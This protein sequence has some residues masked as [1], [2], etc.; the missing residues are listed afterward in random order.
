MGVLFSYRNTSAF[1]TLSSKAKSYFIAPYYKY[2]YGINDDIE[3]V[4]VA[5]LVT[6]FKEMTSSLFPEGFEYLEYGVGFSAIPNYYVNEKLL[7]RFPL[8]VQT[9][10]KYI[11]NKVP[12]DIGFI[13]KAINNIGFQTSI[14]YGISSEY[15]INPRWIV[16]AN[17]LR[18]STINDSIDKSKATYYSLSTTYSNEDWS[19]VLGYKTVKDIANYSENAYMVSVQY[20]W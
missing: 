19:Y 1:D 18:T 15:L 3:I 14:N 5:N 11:S 6:S 8:G 9:I 2:Y 12:E 4:G 16:D 7:F 13:V 17:I 10:K 20:N